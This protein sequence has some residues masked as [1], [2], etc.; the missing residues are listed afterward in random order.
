[1][2]VC[3]YCN[4]HLKKKYDVCPG[5]GGKSFKKVQNYGETK[6]MNPPKGGYQ[7]NLQNFQYQRKQHLAGF[8][9]GIIIIVFG[10]AVCLPF[11]FIK[12]LMGEDAGAFK[13][14]SYIF[15]LFGIIGVFN[16]IK[17]ALPFFK[18]SH[19]VRTG[20]N[21]DIK[22]VQYLSQHGILIKN[23]K[24]E[25]EPVKGTIN[26]NKTIY[27]IKVIYEIEKGKTKCFKSEPKYLTKLGRDDGT[28]DL[29]V[30]PKDYSNYFVD[31]EIY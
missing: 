13:W 26:S 2:Y 6:I 30:D 21:K 16:V 11:L 12:Q 27:V 20:A 4:R 22:K 17:T 3:E 18:D 19:K 24:Y 10:I 8:I 9:P 28:V 29:L 25:I 1:M 23:L 14:F 7:V 5:C 15:V 31:F